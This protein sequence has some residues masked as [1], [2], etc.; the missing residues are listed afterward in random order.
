MRR[1]SIVMAAVAASLGIIFAFNLLNV[2]AS[3]GQ[4]LACNLC[5]T[6]SGSLSISTDAAAATVAPGQSFPVNISWAGGTNGNRTE[7][8]FPDVESNNLFGPSPRIPFSSS[9]NAASGATSSTLTAPSTTGTYTVRVF[10][11][12][13]SP[14]DSDFADVAV[15][16]AE[17]VNTA[18]V[19]NTIGNKTA[20]AGQSLQFTVS[21]TDPEGDPL[22]YSASN[23]P[24]GSSFN[25]STRIFT[26]TPSAPGTFTNVTFQVSDGALTDSES[27]TITVAAPPNTAP[28]LN[29]IGNK[30]VTAGQPLQFTVSATDPEGDPLTYPASNL[31][32][33]SSFNPSTRVFTWTPSAP[34]TFTNVT[35]QVS[36]GALTDSESIT[37]I[38][39]ENNVNVAPVLDPIGNKSVSA[40]QLLE[41]T[42]SATDPNGDPLT[43]MAS[44]LPAGAAFNPSTRTFY[45]TPAAA[46]TYSSI[47][48][49]VLD[50][51]LNDFELITI[52][53]NAAN[54]APVLNNVGNKTVTA[55]QSLQ[56]TVSATDPDG[57]SLTYSASNLPAGAGF[58]SST[59]AFSWTPA[60]AGTY[61]NISFQVSDGSLND[62]ESITI[63]V[64]AAVNTAPT[65]SSIGNMTVAAGHLLQFAITS[66]DP[67]GDPLT[68][69][70]SNLPAGA[71]FNASTGV[72]SWTPAT[73]GTYTGIVFRVSDG[74]L[75]DTETITIYVNNAN[76]APALS[77]IGNRTVMVGQLL[78]FTVAASD[79]NGDSLT[80]SVSDLPPGATFNTSTRT[81][82]W[83]PSSAG[84]YEV[85]FAVSDGSLSDEQTVII[86]AEGPPVLN[87]IGNKT[88]GA[89]ELL[90]FT[91]SASDPDGDELAYYASGL[92]EG[93]AF[94]PSTRTFSWTPAGEQVGLYTGIHFEVSDGHQ[95]ASE[96]IV[97]VVVESGTAI[98]NPLPEVNVPPEITA[99]G[100]REVTVGRILQFMV[101]A[102]DGNYDVLTYNALNLPSGATF[103]ASTR[104]F[105]WKPSE[106]QVGVFPGIVF[107]VSDGKV[108]DSQGITITVSGADKT[109]PGIN[110]VQTSEV[111]PDSV[112]IRWKTDEPGTSQVEY[113]ASPGKL[114]PLD[115]ELVTEHAVRL[116]GLK[117]G[118]AYL[119]RTLSIDRAGNLSESAEL[120]F[121][122]PPAVTVGE[123][124]IS[125]QEAH[126][127]EEVTIDVLVVNNLEVP[128]SKELILR[129]GDAEES[130]VT[131]DLAPGELR[132]VSFTTTRYSAGLAPVYVNGRAGTLVIKNPEPETSGGFPAVFFSLPLVGAAVAAFWIVRRRRFM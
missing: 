111:R 74:S 29:S 42:V 109:A 19:L 31:P 35:F 76:A 119:Y 41:F 62:S 115:S 79:P 82:T 7:V 6:P 132:W 100:D 27:I 37:I 56:F 81:F 61:S 130:A 113:R 92:P 70:A 28:V 16:V 71:T 1:I 9:N 33:G 15:T 43:Y 90:K 32:A 104:T 126:V 102:T 124:M 101:S 84:T 47:T 60:T 2:S 105:T 58:N 67:D 23:L 53:V 59:G 106:E 97:I 85:V 44:N 11:A 107:E 17:P 98:Q 65:L 122:T 8:N 72:F 93:A 55:G 24:A 45:W 123:L 25:P 78:K 117:P 75:N 86:H 38:V 125:P 108:K 118:S 80:Y 83:T 127:G 30:A 112:V 87:A 128:Y 46:G 95:T 22:T 54:A 51:S 50:A 66:S 40:G 14:R 94:N 20:T 91:I 103:S 12:R 121:T 3:S 57:D 131:V 64:N 129:I 26:W 88:I 89:G 34:G 13:G 73:A 39:S 116:E 114:S 49:R 77:A 63:T 5:H 4:S 68:Y 110:S 36:D 52:T 69:S 96:N 10:I 48:F 21:A 99:I 120:E 18:P